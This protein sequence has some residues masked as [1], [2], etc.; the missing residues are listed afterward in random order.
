MTPS[1]C[2]F[3]DTKDG[4]RTRE[5]VWRRT[6]RSRF[7]A[8]SSLSFWQQSDATNSTTERP[9]SQFD[10]TLNAVCSDCNAG[11]LN[12][13][14]DRAL[15]CLDYFGLGRG[16]VPGREEL[17]D[18]AFWAVVRALLRTHV[19]LGG[20]AP[21]YLFKAAFAE[22]AERRVPAGCVVQIAP[23][24]PVDIEAG[25][26]Q[27]VVVGGAYLG[28]VAVSFGRLFLSVTLGGPDARTA[29]YAW[30]AATQTS[31]WFP[32]QFWQLAP[33]FGVP[34]TYHQPLTPTEAW[35]AGSSLGFMLDLGP[36]D[37]FGNLL[38][39]ESVVPA[40]ARGM[41]PWPVTKSWRRSSR[42]TD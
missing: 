8:S 22:H 35:I 2:L 39:F 16:D 36:R 17:S 42:N 10:I 30:R 38:D 26:H 27:S 40:H 41:V 23:T 28:Q 12:D 4:K 20:H 32:D 25:L 18:L 5:H 3:C 19:S 21:N 24:L 13:L 29:Q 14:E 34:S 1:K 33:T 7:P 11:W 15:P 9:I 31:M 6:L 37:Q